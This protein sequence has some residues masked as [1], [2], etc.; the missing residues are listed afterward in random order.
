MYQNII[1]QPNFDDG[2]GA[3]AKR[4][5]YIEFLHIPSGNL[6]NFKGILTAFND[7]YTSNWQEEDVYGKMDP[8]SNFR[9]TRRTITLGWD[10]LASSLEEAKDNLTKISL[11]IQMLYP[12]YSNDESGVSAMDANPVLKMGF[13]NLIQ[14]SEKQKNAGNG[15]S[16]LVGYINGTFSPIPDLEAGFFDPGAS[17]YPKKIRCSIS[18]TVLHTNKLGWNGKNFRTGKFPYGLKT[19]TEPKDN[20]GKAQSKQNIVGELTKTTNYVN[21]M[22]ES[23]SAKQKK[24]TQ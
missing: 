12:S 24:V 18:Y 19:G 1:K 17:L 14:D 21:K 11:L 3:L 22:V 5:F 8:I 16:G 4:G 6:V 13:V 7:S 10:L 15:Q 2:T 20:K 9:N 23:I